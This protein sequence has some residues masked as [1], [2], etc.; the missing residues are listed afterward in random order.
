MRATPTQNSPFQGV[1]ISQIFPKTHYFRCVRKPLP[2]HFPSQ[3]GPR[4][5]E[6]TTYT[7]S[8]GTYYRKTLL[9]VMKTFFTLSAG[10]YLGG[11]VTL[12][13]PERSVLRI[14]LLPYNNPKH[15]PWAFPGTSISH[16]PQHSEP[17]SMI[18]YWHMVSL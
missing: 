18:S 13:F 12:M 7:C 17:H 6:T 11:Y 1:E 9:L 15:T 14:R 10:G 4:L 5:C 16:V 8:C 2:Y 3:R